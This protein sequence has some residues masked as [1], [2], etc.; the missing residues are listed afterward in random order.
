VAGDAE[1]HAVVHIERR[2]AVIDLDDVIRDETRVA[3]T[4]LLTV[5]TV[6]ALDCSGPTLVIT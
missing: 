4:A 5:E 2:A 1:R 3:R 6:T